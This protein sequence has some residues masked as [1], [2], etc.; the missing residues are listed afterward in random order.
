MNKKNSSVRSPAK[1]YPRRCAECGSVAVSATTIPYKAEVKHDGKL[2]KF[3]IAKLK[4]DKCAA[5]GE[6]FFTNSTDEQLTASLRSAIGLLPPEEIRRQLGVLGI[7]QRTFAGH[8]RIAPETVSRW[9]TGLAIQN[10][11]LDTFMRIYF[12]FPAVRRSLAKAD[13]P[14]DSVGGRF[15]RV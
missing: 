4:I 12:A 5:C 1:P 11:A 2:H 7:S 10:R 3:H 6:E 13:L 15:V 14:S 8:L 9:M